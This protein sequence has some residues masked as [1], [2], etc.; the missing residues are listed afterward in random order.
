M[1]YLIKYIRYPIKFIRYFYKILIY[2]TR[3]F[4]YLVFIRYLINYKISHK[5]IL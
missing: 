3:Y 4:I 5:L 2:Y 1:K